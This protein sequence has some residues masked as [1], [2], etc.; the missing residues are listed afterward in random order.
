MNKIDLAYG[1][2]SIKFNYDE[3]RFQ[4]LTQQTAEQ[5]VLSDAQI[6]EALDVPIGSPPLGEILSA[7][8]SVLIVVSDAT[9]AT[10]SAQIVNLLVRRVIQTGI[11]PG[12]ISVIFATGIHREVTPLEKREL[13]TPFI[14]DRIKIIDHNASDTAQLISLGTTNRGTQ[15][16]LN[17]ALTEHTH[18]II[19]GGVGFHYFAGFTGGRKSICPGLASLETIASTHMLALDF[20][21]GGRRAGVGVGKLAGNAVHEE[22]DE[23]AAMIAP[24]F[25]INVI[26]ND[27]G[28]AGGV[29][30]GQWRE[31]HQAACMEY[32]ATHSVQINAKRALVIASCG[33]SPADI[34]LIQAHKT[35]E[36][37]T[38]A[39]SEGGTIILL[40]ECREGLGRN[41]FLKWFEESDSRALEVRLRDNFVI[42]GQTAWALM[43]KTERY[44][45]FLISQLPVEQVHALRMNPAQ[46]LA[47]ALN[48]VKPDI[49]GFI[50]PHGAAVL[51]VAAD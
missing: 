7:G 15:A 29:Y 47:E 43:T 6:G 38:H 39:C 50:L 2:S 33:G 40:A 20:D 18:V 17:R 21:K 28:S 9:R 3:K 5:N 11:A 35:L 34:N 41:D 10:A 42:N 19:I 46:S 16:Q 45:I 44:R 48:K 36:M 37:A 14:A 31:A 1:H 51:P 24:A 13:L 27:H 8:D 32:L 4:V 22:C 26:V 25:A 23:I 49:S 30:A 12:D